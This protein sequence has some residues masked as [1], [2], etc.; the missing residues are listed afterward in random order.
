MG[1]VFMLMIKRAKKSRGMGK[2]QCHQLK[3]NNI[4]GRMD[5]IKKPSCPSCYFF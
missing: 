2:G 1:M 5:K 4:M 3:K